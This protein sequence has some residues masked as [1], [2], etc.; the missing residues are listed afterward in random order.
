MPDKTRRMT[1][2]IAILLAIIALSAGVFVAQHMYVKK[3]LDASQ[4]NGT[5]L[6]EA[7]AVQPFSLTGIDHKPFDNASLHGSWTMVFFGFTNCG[8]MCPTT[9]AELGKTYR[10]LEQQ[11]VKTLPNIVMISVDP[12]RD[13][14]E[15]LGHYVKAFDPHFYGARGSQ[16]AI[17]G[18]TREL[19]IAYLNVARN[20]TDDASNYDIEHT[21]S[22][23]LF[24]PQG[25]LVAF[26]TSPLQAASLAK[27][28]TLLI[29]G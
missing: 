14:L 22:V 18:M 19:G 6:D 25:A 15:K 1:L 3:K 17:K 23:M 26:F 9:M 13:S 21:G 27:D 7:R 12:A 16:T 28:Y 4:L 29:A 5:L 24:N 20:D 11:G 10:L 2:T 8:Y